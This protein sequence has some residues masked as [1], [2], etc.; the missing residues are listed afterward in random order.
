MNTPFT[1]KGLKTLK[2]EWRYL[3]PTGS[4]MTVLILEMENIL[5]AQSPCYGRSRYRG[6]SAALK[7][8]LLGAVKVTR[9]SRSK[10]VTIL[11]SAGTGHAH[12]YEVNISFSFLISLV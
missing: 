5:I 9:Y 4:F 2:E 6:V 10:V 12:Y 7:V 11:R 3:P 8:Q 1:L